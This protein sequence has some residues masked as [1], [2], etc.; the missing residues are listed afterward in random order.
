MIADRSPVTVTDAVSVDAALDDVFQLVC[1]PT[2][3][4][5]CVSGE[6]RSVSETELGI[7]Y[8]TSTGS[9]ALSAELRTSR[10]EPPRRVVYDL[11]G[12]LSGTIEWT[13]GSDGDDTR[14]SATVSADPTD[15]LA[16]GD[17]P[18][19][20]ATHADLEPVVASLLVDGLDGI[21]TAAERPM[22][23]PEIIG[24]PLPDVHCP[25]T[26]TQN[27][28]VET[29]LEPA[30]AWVAERGLVEDEPECEA[31]FPALSFA[32][33]AYPTASKELLEFLTD[34]YSW[35][36][37]EDDAR[38]E[39]S[40][41][42]TPVELREHQRPHLAVLRDGESVDSHTPLSRTFATLRDRWSAWGTDTWRTRFEKH[43][44]D[45]FAAHRWEARN[46]SLGQVPLRN[47]Y[48]RNKQI[49]AGMYLIYDLVALTGGIERS[50]RLYRH[51]VYNDLLEA[52][53]NVLC[54]TNDI[55]SL[56]KELVADDVNNFVAVVR[57]EQQCS[58][59]TA[60]ETVTELIATETE[61][62]ER[63]RTRLVDET[64]DELGDRE[65]RRTHLKRIEQAISGHLQFS[66]RAFRYD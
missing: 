44:L 23:P 60:V 37:I 7:R 15:R 4:A 30:A 31:A 26:P 50:S 46:R 56:E 58:M 64:G 9:L 17:S 14:L 6:T 28:H 61:R 39:S 2:V 62:F 52:G 13:L 54:W 55:Y 45:Y 47:E 63:L 19:G 8:G 10:P 34:W 33:W 66:E 49:A 29:I 35:G 42:E 59:R 48:L 20:S 41:S 43:H 16:T 65:E 36:F 22:P 57:Q 40:L 18:S 11:D 21:R 53:A 51:P 38:D 5:D 32:S 3:V 1:S 12:D 27:P 24:F 25:Y